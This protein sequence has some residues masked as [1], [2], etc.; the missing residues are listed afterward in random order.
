MGDRGLGKFSKYMVKGN[1][2][3][4]EGAKSVR[5][6]HGD[7]GFFVE[8]LDRTAGE[9][10]SSA[11]VIGSHTEDFLTRGFY[12]GKGAET[13]SKSPIVESPNTVTKET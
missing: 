5:S 11:E 8:L 7:F 3:R 1:V 10:L 12:L 4:T 9:L 13:H 2:D 6:S